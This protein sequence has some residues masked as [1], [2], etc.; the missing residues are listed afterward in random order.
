[1]WETEILCAREKNYRPESLDGELREGRLLWYGAGKGLAAFCRPEDLDLSGPE[2]GEGDPGPFPPGFFERPRDYWEIKDACGGSLGGDRTLIPAIWEQVW[3]GRLSSDTWEAQRRAA[4]EGIVN[5]GN[6][7]TAGDSITGGPFRRVPKALQSRAALRNLWK[8]GS[9]LPGRWF[10]LD[11]EELSGEEPWY[12]EELDRERVR[13]L[14]R[15]WGILCRPLLEREN[16][17]L[18]W[19]RL[20][21]AMR[22]ME[23]AGELTAGYF[24]SGI[25]SLQFASPAIVRNLEEAEE[26][27][28]REL[29]WLNAADPASSA[30]LDI[31]GLDPRL[32]ARS[33]RNRL[34]Y[35]GVRLIAVSK[36]NGKELE[37]FI[38]PEDPDLGELVVLYKVPRQRN[39]SPEKKLVVETINGAAA[40]SSPYGSCFVEGGFIR[41]REKL[42]LW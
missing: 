11:R 26:F 29:Y 25:R 10:S 15:R 22:R 14:L 35:R 38:P 7:V 36:R 16:F 2:T 9:P 3:K 24:F 30:A 28:G 6:T 20:L 31:E 5:S 41:D 4:V 19:A 23:L 18:S 34:Y 37:I 21:P 27:G 40:G 1:L 32:P 39:P 8:Q 13:L 12:Q 17:L 33:A 42:Y